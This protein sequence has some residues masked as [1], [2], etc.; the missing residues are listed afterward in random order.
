[1]AAEYFKNPPLGVDLSESRTARNNSVGIVLFTLSLIAV[2]LRIFVRLRLKHEPLG[3]DDYLMCV[4][5]VF[6]AGNLAC[7]IAGGFF[8][9]GKHIW[10]LDAYQM[11]II[12]IVLCPSSFCRLMR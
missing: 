12:T 4:G 1:M 10:S 11:R 5:L 9:L 2:V 3:L 6:N 8:G 7:F